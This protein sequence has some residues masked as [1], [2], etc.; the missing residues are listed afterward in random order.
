MTSY[1]GS[2]VAIMAKENI[3][4]C[5]RYFCK[6]IEYLNFSKNKDIQ[7]YKNCMLTAE[8]NA[9]YSTRNEIPKSDNLIQALTYNPFMK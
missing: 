4:P 2:R 1:I 7:F 8:R 5:N 3:L 9:K 6:C